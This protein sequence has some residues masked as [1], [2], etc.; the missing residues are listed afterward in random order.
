MRKAERIARSATR[1][2][3]EPGDDVASANTVAA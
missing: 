1:R 3:L 2:P